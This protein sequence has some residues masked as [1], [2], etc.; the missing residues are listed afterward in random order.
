[1]A[2]EMGRG[3]VSVADALRDAL[4]P[5]ITESKALRTDMRASDAIQ[6]RRIM[7][8]LGGLAVV[9]LLVFWLAVMVYQNNQLSQQLNNVTAQI[10]DCTTAGGTCYEQGSSRTSTAIGDIIAA[11]VFMAECARLF[12]GEVGPAY[13]KKLEKCVYDRLTQAAA[14]RAQASPSPSPSPQPSPSPTQ[15]SR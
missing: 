1:M 7:I 8:N 9:G 4:S 11:N 12:P 10:A 5:L 2:N 15:L 6:R 3:Q 14:Q 13:D